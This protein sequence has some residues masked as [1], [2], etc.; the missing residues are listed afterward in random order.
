[1]RMSPGWLFFGSVL[2]FGV[3]LYIDEIAYRAAAQVLAWM[4]GA[5]WLANR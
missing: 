4:S 1:M 5:I 3:G 2:L